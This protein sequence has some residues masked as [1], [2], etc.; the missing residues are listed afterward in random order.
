MNKLII[1]VEDARIMDEETCR[2][3][4]LSTMDLIKQAGEK[5]ALCFREE[6]HPEKEQVITVIAGVGNN[7]CDSMIMGLSL[8]RIGFLVNFIVVGNERDIRREAWSIIGAIRTSNGRIL[9]IDS[10]SKLDLFREFL[11]RSAFLV[12]GLFGTGLNKNIEGLYYQVISLM[13]S[14]SL[15]IFSVDI[16]S[17][18]NGNSG[19]P[20]NI[21]V[22]AS[23]TGIIQCHK[24][25][26]LFGD[27]LDYSGK[28]KVLEIG[29]LDDKI[30]KNKWLLTKEDLRPLPPRRHNSHKYHY[31]SV[32]VVGGSLGMLGAP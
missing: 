31:G 15:P 7:G 9:I 24:Y 28:R 16:P 1:S 19:K 22:K 4:N 8:W 13:N 27:A 2:R 20:A 21:A 6:M 30:I 11:K 17:G 10:E 26:N 29:L 12:D 32:L 3:K 25:G 14:S 23:L 18:L 5:L